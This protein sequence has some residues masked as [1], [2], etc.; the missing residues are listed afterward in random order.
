MPWTSKKTTRMFLSSRDLGPLVEERRI[1]LHP[2]PSNPVACHVVRE[3]LEHLVGAVAGLHR[4]RRLG[5]GLFAR[6]EDRRREQQAQAPPESSVPHTAPARIRSC[7]CTAPATLPSLSTTGQRDHAVALHGADRRR[8]EL[9]RRRGPRRAGHYAAHRQVQERRVPLGQAGEVASGEHARQA[10]PVDHH[11]EPA[12]VGQ[13]HH[14]VPHRRVGPEHVA[15]MHHHVAHAEQQLPAERAAGMKRREVLPTEPLHL[16]QHHR[17]RVAQRQ[18]DGRA[19]RRR[20]VVRAGLLLHGPVERHR[21]HPGERRVHGAG[22]RDDRHAE[23]LQRP[24]QSEQLL[25]LAALAEHDGHVAPAHQAQVAMQRVDRV[26]VGGD[27]A[28]GRERRRDL[29]RD[30]AG[31][32]DAGDDHPSG[33]IG[34]QAHRPGEPVVEALRGR[35]YRPALDL[36]DPAAEGDERRRIKRHGPR[37]PRS[38]ARAARTTRRAPGG[39][40]RPLRAPRRGRRQPS[41]RRPPP[42]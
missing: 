31:L 30:Q 13:A 38:S 32:A 12:I 7:R 16:Q 39:A 10:A 28:G 1:G 5:A 18:G 24:H 11:R 14:G 6:R 26:Q 21:G 25:R 22:D 33:R 4:G 19:R 40:P 20:Q 29:P 34:Q 9:V 41:S 35:R 27:G 2:A 15:R 3:A 8:G 37:A 42:P 36:D 23:P 17:E